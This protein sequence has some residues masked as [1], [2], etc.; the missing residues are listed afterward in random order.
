M[1]E[2]TVFDSVFKTMVHKLPG[3]LVPFVN[4]VFSENYANDEDIVLLS[5]EHERPWHTIID[6]LFTKRLLVLA[7][8]YLMRYEG[9]FE[10]ISASKE[11]TAALV[12]ECT[13][14]RMRL[15]QETLDLGGGATYERLIE[16][17][18]RI[19]DYLLE[20]YEAL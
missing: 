14:L 6:E 18:I 17:I 15:A 8:F 12:T 3:L 4:D 7:P 13:E 19:S 20:R 1:A 9:E 10:T 11:G 5:D 16:L 2:N